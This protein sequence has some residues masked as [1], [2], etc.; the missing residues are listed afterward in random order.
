M[1][2][3]PFLKI[4]SNQI[5]TWPA[6]FAQGL[7]P[8]CRISNHMPSKVSNDIP[9]L[10]QNFNGASVEVWGMGKNYYPTLYYKQRIQPFSHGVIEFNSC[11]NLV[12]GTLVCFVVF[13]DWF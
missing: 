6:I 13:M 10:F 1:V 3:A 5:C 9:Y 11:L 4:K 2:F 8:P 12:K 7:G